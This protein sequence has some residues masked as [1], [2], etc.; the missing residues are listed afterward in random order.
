VSVLRNELRKRLLTL[1]LTVLALDAAAIAIYYGARLATA[2]VT[3]R[4]VFTVVWT[5]ATVLVVGVQLRGIRR[6]RFGRGE[7]R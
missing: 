2:P 7:R 4:R 5:L 1:V 3:T 6:A